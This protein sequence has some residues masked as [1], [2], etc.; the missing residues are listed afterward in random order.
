MNEALIFTGGIYSLI[1]VIFHALFWR[2]FD[3]PNDL[4]S[5]SFINRAVIQVLN[6]SLTFVFVSFSYL[7]LIHTQELLV[8][9]L[10]HA[11]LWLIAIFWLARAV[12]QV[13][14]FKLTHWLSWMFTAYFTLGAVL[15]GIP[16]LSVT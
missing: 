1:L 12:Q 2:L 14:F 10:G 6:I 11:L 16:A 13:I 3:W 7:S 15:Y 9:E 5:L 4:R 8:T